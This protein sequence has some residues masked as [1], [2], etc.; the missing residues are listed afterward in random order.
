[1]SY[2][3]KNLP[4]ISVPHYAGE[5]YEA[6]VPDTLDLVEKAELS[7]QAITRMLD[8][9]RDYQMATVAEFDRRPPVI[10]FASRAPVCEAKHLESLPLLRIMSGSAFNI[11]SDK[12]FMESLLRLTAKDGAV[13]TPPYVADKPDDRSA[14]RPP[15]EAP[16]ILAPSAHYEWKRLQY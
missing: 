15:F 13:Y 2:P 5:R 11:E 1:M 10:G 16:G 14:G 9:D 7:I 3:D 6:D 4:E 8:P 12:R